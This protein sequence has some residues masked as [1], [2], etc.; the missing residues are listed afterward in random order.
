MRHMQTWE[1]W[2]LVRTFQLT[3]EKERAAIRDRRRHF[4]GQT[5]Q[6]SVA[7]DKAV[8]PVCSSRKQ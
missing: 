7:S 6:D 8:R 2:D 5:P 3:P 1:L 4:K